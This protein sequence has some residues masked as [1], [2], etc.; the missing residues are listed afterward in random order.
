MEGLSGETSVLSPQLQNPEPSKTPAA[1]SMPHPYPVPTPSQPEVKEREENGEGKSLPAHEQPSFVEFAGEHEEKRQRRDAGEQFR[2][3]F[4]TVDHNGPRQILL[5]QPLL[6]ENEPIPLTNDFHALTFYRRETGN[7][8]T[9][10]CEIALH[11][12]R[13]PNKFCNTGDATRLYITEFNWLI[14]KFDPSNRVGQHFGSYANRGVWAMPIGGSDLWLIVAG[15]SMDDAGV[16][17]NPV[18]VSILKQGKE[19]WEVV[20]A[21]QQRIANENRK[22]LAER[23]NFR[24]QPGQA[25]PSAEPVPHHEVDRRAGFGD[26]TIENYPRTRRSILSWVA[27]EIILEV[28]D[29][30]RMEENLPSINGEPFVSCTNALGEVIC[31]HSVCYA[32]RSPITILFAYLKKM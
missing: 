22:P 2:K 11:F 1:V 3:Q 10:V 13:G 4:P 26:E 19:R 23:G 7:R 24:M 14:G 18:E 9:L 8:T 25:N 31:A 17:L 29:L 20:I 15:K 28:R 27:Q 6:Q 12:P 21:S 32:R 16:I 30:I 5:W